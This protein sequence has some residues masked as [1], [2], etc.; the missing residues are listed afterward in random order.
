MLGQNGRHIQSGNIGSMKLVILYPL[1]YLVFL[2]SCVNT[3]IVEENKVKQSSNIEKSENSTYIFQNCESKTTCDELFD[4]YHSYL[5]SDQPF[6]FNTLKESQN[7]FNLDSLLGCTLSKYKSGSM[8]KVHCLPINWTFFK[9]R[10]FAKANLQY[11][12]FGNKQNPETFPG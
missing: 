11:L 9:W 3:K 12:C 8:K 1:I 5:L 10:K 6:E 4:C 7:Y 2:T